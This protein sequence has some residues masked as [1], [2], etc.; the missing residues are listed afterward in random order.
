MFKGKADLRD[1][2]T[3]AEV[4]S[5]T[6]TCEDNGSAKIRVVLKHAITLT[7]TERLAIYSPIKDEEVVVATSKNGVATEIHEFGGESS[8]GCLADRS[9][10]S[11]TRSPGGPLGTLLIVMAKGMIHREHH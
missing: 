5:L 2:E 1:P 3:N 4:A 9:E 11:L 7:G 8:L 10:V 6:E